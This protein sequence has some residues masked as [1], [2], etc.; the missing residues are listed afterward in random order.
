MFVPFT[1]SRA[2]SP[3]GAMTVL[4]WTWWSYCWNIQRL[5]A[6]FC[7]PSS[8][9]RHSAGER[10]GSGSADRSRSGPVRGRTFAVAPVEGRVGEQPDGDAAALLAFVEYGGEAVVGDFAYDVGT[11]V[12]LVEYLADL[13]LASGLDDYEHTLLGLAE[14]DLVGFH[15]GLAAGRSG[16]VYPKTGAGVGGALDAGAGEARRAEVLDA[17]NGVALGGFEAGF[18]EDFLEERVADLDGGPEFA[19]VLEGSRGE[20]GRAVYAVAPGVGADE[21]EQVAGF[22]GGRSSE[23]V[24][25]EKADAHGVDERVAG[26]AWGEV[27]LAAHVGDADT[28]AVAGYAGYYALEQVLAPGFGERAEA[29][30]VE[31][32]DGTRAHGEYVSDYAADAGGRAFVGFYGGGVVVGLDFHDDGPA[33]A[34]VHDAGVLAAGRD[35]QAGAVGVEH[36]EQG[37]GVLVAAVLAPE[38]AEKAEF[39]GVGFASKT[40]DYGFVFGLG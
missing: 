9:V 34:D 29:E 40:L 11:Q 18:Y 8:V 20:A 19:L 36:T 39:E 27:H 21:H 26:V 1:L 38:G 5:L 14:H 35:E 2:A 15:S 13:A 16:Y 17:D 12:P 37:L 30:G 31:Q 28:V 25:L 7:E 3:P 23:V 24:G 32:G 10:S 22:A 6:M 4:V 33:V